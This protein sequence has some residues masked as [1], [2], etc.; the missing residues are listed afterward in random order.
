MKSNKKDCDSESLDLLLEKNN[1]E[2]VNFELFGAESQTQS[3]F[4][5]ALYY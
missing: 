5:L 3:A 4:L 1:M 2:L